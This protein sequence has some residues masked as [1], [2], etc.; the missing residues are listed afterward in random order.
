MTPQFEHNCILCVLLGFEKGRDFY[1]CPPL[2]GALGEGMLT[3]R[4]GSSPDS[5]QSMAASEARTEKGN[6]FLPFD[7]YVP[8]TLPQT[9]SPFKKALALM[10]LKNQKL[11]MTIEL[12]GS[13]TFFLSD[14]LLPKREMGLEEKLLLRNFLTKRMVQNY[15]GAQLTPEMKLEIRGALVKWLEEWE[16][17]RS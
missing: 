2:P 15:K 14:F 11:S 8:L 13:A 16:F 17:V 4:Y 6:S 5:F 10:E 12:S 3:V 1:W 9:S 7:K